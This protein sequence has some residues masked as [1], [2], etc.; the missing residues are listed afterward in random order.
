MLLIAALPLGYLWLRG[1]G[2]S[3]ALRLSMLSAVSLFLSFD[4]VVFGA[5]TRLYDCGLA[6]PDWPGC[7][8]QA[9]PLDAI[10]D[11][12]LA[13]QLAPTGPASLPKAWIEMIHRYLAM[14]VGL[15]IMVM[16]AYSWLLWRRSTRLCCSGLCP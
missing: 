6:C 5:F 14:T 15:L 4:L 8:G 3:A 12:R 9:S 11:S 16:A 7:Y 1:R 13:E 10:G 2:A